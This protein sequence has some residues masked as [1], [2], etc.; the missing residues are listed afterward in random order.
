MDGFKGHRDKQNQLQKIANAFRRSNVHVLT[1]PGGCTPLIQPL[2][3]SINKSFKVRIRKL[4]TE[5]MAFSIESGNEIKPPSKTKVVEWIE[6]AWK[7]I[8][9]LT[10]VKMI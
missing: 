3:V 4:W 6:T 10:V 7:E 2:D 9:H 1:S 8:P 5:W